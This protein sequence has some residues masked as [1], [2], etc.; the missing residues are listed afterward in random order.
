MKANVDHGW[1]Q[2]FHDSSQ[3]RHQTMPD[4]RPHLLGCPTIGLG[5][6]KGLLISVGL[7]VAV[8]LRVAVRA[9]VLHWWRAIA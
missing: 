5:V 6:V 7:L 3:T 4:E 9:L 8:G 2:A 1:T